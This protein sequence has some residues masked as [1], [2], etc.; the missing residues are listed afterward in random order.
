MEVD[1]ELSWKSISR[2]LGGLVEVL[3]R[4]HGG[5]LE[6]GWKS[7]WQFILRY[8]ADDVGASR[9]VVESL[10]LTVDLNWS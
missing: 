10:W 1:S 8:G 2:A 9:S 5:Q 6:V 3:W 4:P 7:S